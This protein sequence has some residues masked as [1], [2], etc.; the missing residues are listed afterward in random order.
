MKSQLAE[1]IADEILSLQK[2]WVRTVKKKRGKRFRIN[3]W[4][5]MLQTKNRIAP[6]EEQS[7]EVL[8]LYKISANAG[9]DV[10][11][12]LT[13]NV[14]PEDEP[15]LEHYETTA[16]FEVLYEF[17]MDFKRAS[18]KVAEAIEKADDLILNEA[19]AR[20]SGRYGPSWIADYVATPG[21]FSNL[22]KRILENVNMKTEYKWTFINAVSAARNTSYSVMFGSE[23]LAVLTETGDARRAVEAEKEIM[24]EMWLR[25]TKTQV[26]LMKRLR[27]ESFNYEK[28]LRMFKEQICDATIEAAEAGV[29]Y[30]NLTLI[31]FWAAGDFHHISQTTYN[32]CK[33]DVE[34]AILE[35]LTDALERTLRKAIRS[36]KLDDPSAIPT[37]EVTSAAAAHIMRLD[38][39]TSDMINDL[40]TKRY[41]NL[42]AKDPRIF[43]FE[44]MN[45]E[46]VNFLAQGERIIEKPPRGLGGVVHGIK[47]DLSDVDK[48]EVLKNPQKYSWPECPITARFSALLRFADDPFHLHSD[49][50]ICMYATEL[51]ALHPEKPYLPYFFCKQCTS[52]RLLPN[53]CKYCLAEKKIE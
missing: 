45:E 16:V 47:I 21:S 2:T 24:K 15:W 26:Q 41:Y 48:N 46:F 1:K 53:K 28:C 40:F 7:K 52:A 32:I 8:N 49:P 13:E 12:S 37:W 27:Q 34:M 39:F 42:L 18:Q 31:P 33:G 38:G 35:C 44:C 5:P 19:L 22:L 9:Y 51:I 6:H 36:G 29:H 20:F 11:S 25:P 3:D 50:L 4:R 14:R 10:L 30:A 17:D 43:R 23:F